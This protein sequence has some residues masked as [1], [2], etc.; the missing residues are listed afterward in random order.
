MDFLLVI[1]NLYLYYFLNKDTSSDDANDDEH[2]NTSMVF[3]REDPS[4]VH[5][6]VHVAPVDIVDQLENM[7]FRNIVDDVV[8]LDF[9]P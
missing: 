2:N 3:A 6:L 9:F 5:D 7:G 4:R 8:V 1:Y